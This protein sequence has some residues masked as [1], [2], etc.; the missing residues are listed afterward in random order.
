MTDKILHLGKMTS[1]EIA[2]WMGIAY[3]TYRKNNAQRLEYLTNFADFTKY[4]GGVEIKEIYIPTFVKNISVEDQYYIDAIRETSNGLATISGITRKLKRD[5]PEFKD[6]PEETLYKR[7]S[8]AGD[9]AFGKTADDNSKGTHG[10][11]H[12]I[13][14]IKVDN[15]NYYRFMTAEEEAIYKRI[16][17]KYCKDKAEI[18]EKEALLKDAY[19]KKEISAEEYAE[20]SC[21]LDFFGEV[22]SEFR[23][24]TGLQLVRTTEHEL[25]ESQLIF[26]A[27]SIKEE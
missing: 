14:A 10:T 27:T 5:K 18:A 3:S 26:A 22:L 12:Y 8:K 19:K 16:R 7:M 21:E 1:Q 11:R 25:Y 17:D 13:W 9:R 4:R 6:I 2:D 15:Y 23:A 24:E 20:K